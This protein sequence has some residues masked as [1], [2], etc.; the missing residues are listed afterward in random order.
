M[1]ILHIDIFAFK[2]SLLLYISSYS[3]RGNYSFLNSEIQRSQYIRPKVTVHK[4]AKTIQERKLF[5]GGN[6]LRKYGI[7]K[8]RNMQPRKSFFFNLVNHSNVHFD[9]QGFGKENLD[10]TH[11]CFRLRFIQSTRV[12]ARSALNLPF[13]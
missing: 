12:E 11:L 2:L 5:K 7:R 4:C 1:V 10:P 13:Y 9:D 6:Y 3:F 8:E